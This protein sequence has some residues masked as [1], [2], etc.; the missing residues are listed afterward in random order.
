MEA[1]TTF[2][3]AGETMDFTLRRISE[4]HSIPPSLFVE[5]IVEKC[6]LIN[7]HFLRTKNH[8]PVVANVNATTAT[9]GLHDINIE[10]STIKI[11][12]IVNTS[13]LEQQLVHLWREVHQ[14]LKF[15]HEDNRIAELS[16]INT[17]YNSFAYNRMIVQHFISRVVLSI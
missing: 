14:L 12:T 2:A 3:V 9:I 11:V 4:G 15:Y 16:N 13:D 1:A 10:D 17:Y 5:I 7:Y 8:L 6:H